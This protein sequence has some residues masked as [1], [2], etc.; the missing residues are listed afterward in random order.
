MLVRDSDKCEESLVK[1]TSRGEIE[2]DVACVGLFT[3]GI[4]ANIRNRFTN[5]RDPFDSGY[6]SRSMFKSLIM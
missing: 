5:S 1:I 4:Y 3:T 2:L 6:L